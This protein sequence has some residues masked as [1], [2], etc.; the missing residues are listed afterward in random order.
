MTLLFDLLPLVLFYAT[1]TA[2]QALPAGSVVVAAEQ[3]GNAVSGGVA[4]AR[5]APVILATTV[6]LLAAATQV[7]WLRLRRRRA[8]P[9]LWASVLLV[10]AVGVL[11]LWLH[12]E[13]FVKWKPSVVYWLFGVV[14]WVSQVVLRLNLPRSLLDRR[15]MLADSTWQRLNA[16]WVGFFGLM[17][18]LN[19]WVA[20]NV[21]TAVWIEFNHYGGP[22][23]LAAFVAVQTAF[24]LRHPRAGATHDGVRRAPR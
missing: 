13:T 10:V 4:G 19:L 8:E 15:V 3:M 9:A 21:P 7:A 2:A 5:E 12:D 6:S 14:F 18:L 22:A 24:V 20:Y 11:S 16:A 1:L 23:L 17:G